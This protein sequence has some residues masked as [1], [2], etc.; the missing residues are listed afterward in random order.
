MSRAEAGRWGVTVVRES[1]SQDWKGSM[2]ACSDSRAAFGP[3]SRFNRA[4]ASSIEISAMPL[5]S[6]TIVS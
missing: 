4:C 1:P 3:N 2:S 5:F 6:S